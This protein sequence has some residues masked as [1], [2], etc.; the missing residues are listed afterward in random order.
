M[1]VTRAAV[2]VAHMGKLVFENLR[3]TPK[4]LAARLAAV[5]A[6]AADRPERRIHPAAALHLLCTIEYLKSVQF[7]ADMY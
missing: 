7:F 5:L 4:I 6:D 3:L 1:A 2:A